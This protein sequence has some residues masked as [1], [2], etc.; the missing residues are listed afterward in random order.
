MQIVR[1]YYFQKAAQDAD[2]S[3]NDVISYLWA[4]MTIHVGIIV[5]SSPML[6]PLFSDSRCLYKLFSEYYSMDVSQRSSTTTSRSAAPLQ[7]EDRSPSFSFTDQSSE[8]P[9]LHRISS[10]L[11]EDRSTGSGPTDDGPQLHRIHS[12][13]QEDRSNS[14]S[15]MQEVPNM[16][17]LH[18]M[19][20][21]GLDRDFSAYQTTRSAMPLLILMAGPF[22]MSFGFTIPSEC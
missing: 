10:F 7:L 4:S 9:E 20:S 16:P 3:W 18:R 15:T 17:P 11:R 14:F 1:A 22:C 12:F 13:L 2:F 6:K 21:L 19:A 8:R 5:V